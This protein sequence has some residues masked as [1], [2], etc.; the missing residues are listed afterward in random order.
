MSNNRKRTRQ[1]V[2]KAILKKRY[3]KGIKAAKAVVEKLCSVFQM[4]TKSVSVFTK[5]MEKAAINLLAAREKIR[6]L[7]P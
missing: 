1:R 3:T 4:V 6:R 2:Q 5:E 7:K